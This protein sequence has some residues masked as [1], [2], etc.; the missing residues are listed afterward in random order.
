[1]AEFT[2]KYNLEKPSTT[3]FYSVDPMNQNMDKIDAEL[4]SLSSQLAE[5]VKKSS[6]NNKNLGNVI[7]DNT[8]SLSETTKEISTEAKHLA[9]PCIIKFLNKY[10]IFYRSGTNHSTTF[11]GKIVYKTSDDGVNWS[12]ETILLSND[13]YDYRDPIAIIFGDKLVLRYFYRFN[14]GINRTCVIS[15]TDLVTWSSQKEIPSPNNVENRSRGNM[16]VKDGVLY[17]INY[18]VYANSTFLVS[19]TD[20]VTWNIVTSLVKELT[21]EASITFAENKFICILRQAIYD[22]NNSDFYNPLIWGE[23]KDGITWS[24]KELPIYGHCPSITLLPILQSGTYYGNNKLIVTY[25]DPS[26]Y[27]YTGDSNFNIV[28]L[29]TNGELFST[30]IYNLYRGTWDSGYGDVLIDGNKVFVTYYAY[31]PTGRIYVKTFNKTDFDKLSIFGNSNTNFVEKDDIVYLNYAGVSS[32]KKIKQFLSGDLDVTG[33]GTTEKAFTID[34]TPLNLTGAIISVNVYVMNSTGKFD[35]GV[36]SFS[37]T[38]ITGLLKAETGSTFTS[39][40][41]I[42]WNA[43]NIE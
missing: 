14:N 31:T 3:E 40:N 1:V 20:L 11:D 17:T 32:V 23:S 24:F 34:L 35:V 7:F 12:E 18:D 4:G 42:Y 39:T 6:Y 9:F 10:I 43:I 5:N 36:Q 8:G 13:G 38:A 30:R 19:T 28:V 16:L 29:T 15:T 22:E 25:R 33:D 21:N 2:Q 41:K 26:H 27:N 37:K